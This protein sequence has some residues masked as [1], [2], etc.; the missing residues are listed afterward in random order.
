V[1]EGEAAGTSLGEAGM[2]QGQ[3]LAWAGSVPPGLL[4]LFFSFSVFSFI[5]YLLLF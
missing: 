3:K 1:G 5:F 2:G 4:S